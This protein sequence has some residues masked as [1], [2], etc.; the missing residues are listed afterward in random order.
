MSSNNAYNH[1][2]H[3]QSFI[4]NFILLDELVHSELAEITNLLEELL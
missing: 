1:Q 3:I 4:S 2:A